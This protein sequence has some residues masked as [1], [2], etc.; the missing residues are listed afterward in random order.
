[1]LRSS[2]VVLLAKVET[3]YGTDSAP[4]NTDAVLLRDA[5]VQIL[6]FE[7]VE[8]SRLRPF[9][10]AASFA[11][12]S[13]RARISATVDAAGSGTAGVAPAYGPLLRA[14]GLAQTVQSGVRVDYTPVSTGEE[15]LS[16]YWF[17][18]GM[19][20]RALGC[21]GTFSLDMRAN[22][23]PTLRFDLTGLFETPSAVALPSPT[24]TAWRDGRI[25][26]FANTPTLTID[27]ASV[28]VESFRYDHGVAV[29]YLD[30]IGSRAVH[31]TGRAARATARIHVPA[32][33][34]KNF[35]SL[36]SAET[37]FAV[38]VVHGTSAGN[39]IE[40]QLP[41]CRIARIRGDAADSFAMLDLDMAVLPYAGNDDMT[42]TVR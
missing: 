18:D 21:R 3:A 22:E 42:L 2:R 17:L 37:N 40:L 9:H 32:L 28:V 23:F 30:R 6:D 8:L 38:A 5:D 36:A 19:R 39:T 26:N 29:S 13:P 15:S 1:M 12:A 33:A 16:A 34:T 25:A 24:Y 4:A 41:R 7:Q 35:W 10:G 11:V 27:G 31:I 20:A 14:C